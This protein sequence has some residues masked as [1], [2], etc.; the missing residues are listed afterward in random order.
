MESKHIKGALAALFVAVALYAAN[1][2]S[3]TIDT[4]TVDDDTVRL[5]FD[6]P[7]PAGT[8]AAPD[9][10]P[11]NDGTRQSPWNLAHAIRQLQPGDVL[12]VK[13][14]EYREQMGGAAHYLIETS[15]HEGAW[16]KVRAAD[17][18]PPVIVATATSGIEIVGNYVA[19]IGF[20]IRGEGLN[21]KDAYGYG[22]VARDGH[23]IRL[24][25][26][27]IVDMP[28]GGIAGAHGSHYTIRH[29]LVGRNAFHNSDGGSGISLWRLTNLTGHDGYSNIIEGN[30]AFENAN[31][32]PCNCVDFAGITD[33]GGVI[34]D[35]NNLTGYTGRTLIKGNVLQHNGGR[36][37]NVHDSSHVDVFDNV[38]TSNSATENLHGPRA[39][40]ATHKARDVN[41]A[42]NRI[43]PLPGVPHMHLEGGRP[44]NNT[45]L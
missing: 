2:G 31:H 15:G 14:G 37:I 9:G 23:H 22:I 34:I 18:D 38:T 10:Q 4:N 33:G 27:E 6:Q 19:V 7:E 41:I 13:G 25:H 32:H 17:D 36:G 5:S 28:S 12:N 30:T 40:I 24:E 20:T 45:H 43:K 16:I 11:G 8:W 1:T 21:W 26:N 44:E 29:N 42:G 35:Q 3:T 39:E